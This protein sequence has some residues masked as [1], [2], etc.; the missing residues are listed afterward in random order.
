V[1]EGGGDSDI[2]S[3]MKRLAAGDRRAFT[4]VYEALWPL[5]VARARSLTADLADAEDAAQRA[6]LTPS[7]RSNC[8]TGYQRK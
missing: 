5:C 6:L 3:L 8:R 2:Q 1:R 4:P 7:G